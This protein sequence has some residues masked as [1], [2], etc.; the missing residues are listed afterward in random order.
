MNKCL[1]LVAML[2]FSVLSMAQQPKKV[3]VWETKCSDNSITPFQSIMVR[4]GMETAVANAPGY[5][6][7]DRAAFDAI[8][9]EQNFQRSGAVSDSEIR[10]LGIM[11]GVQNIIVPEAS[12]SDN[13]FYIIVKMLDVETGEYSTAYD[14]LCTA[15]ASDIKQ[16][17]TQLG[18]QLLGGVDASSGRSG[19]SHQK[20]KSERLIYAQDKSEI[21]YCDGVYVY[22][23]KN[24]EHFSVMLNELDRKH[25]RITFTFEASS[26]KGT[27]EWTDEQYPLVL[28]SGWRVLAICLHGDG[29]IFIETNNGR[30]EY[31][32]GLKYTPRVGTEINLE[33]D[34]GRITINGEILNVEMNEYN[35]DNELSSINYSSGNAFHGRIYAVRVYNI[36]E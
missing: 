1:L 19:N 6:G 28:S 30:H 31:R 32:T 4:G 16:T 36:E 10:R 8:V 22:D 34:N 24:A 20:R 11:A 13:D 18:S 5:T 23:N 27:L 7:Y 21:Q 9:K 2:F 33:Y 15:S 17:C 14:A 3:A 26:N 25:F 29:Q 35:G 12:A